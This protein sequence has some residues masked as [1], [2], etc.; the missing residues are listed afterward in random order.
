[1]ALPVPNAIAPPLLALKNIPPA[2]QAVA[3]CSFICPA[4]FLLQLW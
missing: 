2:F 3:E 1:M 4:L